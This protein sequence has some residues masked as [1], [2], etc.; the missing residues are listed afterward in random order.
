MVTDKAANRTPEDTAFRLT[1]MG[2][3]LSVAFWMIIRQLGGSGLAMA[4]AMALFGSLGGLAL[5]M[6]LRSRYAV[7]C[8]LLA[9]LVAVEPAMRGSARKLPY[10][11]LEYLI[12][13]AAVIAVLQRKAPLRLPTLFLC[14]YLLLEI[15]GH[16]AAASGED[17]RWMVVMTGARLGLFLL[18]L[19]SHL[20]PAQTIWVLAAYIAGTLGMAAM[21]LQGAFD[22]ETQWT[23]Q[24]N[25]RAA[26]GFGPNQ[27]AGL[28]ALGAFA[29]VFLA[30][31]DRR[32]WPRLAYLGLVGVQVLAALLTFTRGGSVIL[33]L[34]LMLYVLMLFACGRIS[35]AV[36]G[37]GAVLAGVAWL[38]LQVTDQMLLERYQDSSMSGREDIWTLG[39]RI[40]WD[41]PVF[42]VGTGNFFEASQ[43]RLASY[44]GRVGTHN[45]LIRALSEHGL[46]GASIWLAFVTS[47]LMRV[48][49]EQRGLARAVSLSWL[50]MAVA[51]E[52]HSGL[53]L[54]MSMFFM[55]LA[56]EGFREA[57][58]AP[59]VAVVRRRSPSLRAMPRPAARLEP[60]SSS[61]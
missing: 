43:G 8:G 30:D 48:W 45:E 49:Q 20:R 28:L 1:L 12:I 22:T 21:G 59:A 23:A 35:V 3:G 7:C 5:W 13:L 31:I 51:F 44:H 52:C 34:G 6:A 36:L 41:H 24:S 57:L 29:T 15:A 2:G 37:M 17:A 27:V 39:L 58:A 14:L 4:M 9:Y 11:S 61:A 42:G 50:L 54:S 56:V 53:K 47:A 18:A 10:L 55:A 16:G 33:A 38:A 40:F 46:V 32:W 19:R 60:G 25:T 26:G